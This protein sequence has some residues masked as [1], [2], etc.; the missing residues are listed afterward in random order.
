M[1]P[2]YNNFMRRL[3][4]M[5]R[6]DDLCRCCPERKGF[7][8]GK[9]AGSVFHVPLSKVCK[10][11][12]EIMGYKYDISTS[13]PCDH[14]GPAKAREIAKRKVKEWREKNPKRKRK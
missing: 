2:T 5:L 11:C 13:C 1:K 4:L 7:D 14:Y 3:E 9:F 12:H 10:M 6:R 8:T